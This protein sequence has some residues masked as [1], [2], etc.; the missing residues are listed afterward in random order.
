[1][2]LWLQDRQGDCIDNGEFHY[3]SDKYD[4][5]RVISVFHER[6]PAISSMGITVEVEGNL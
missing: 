2:T 5:L 4:G 1:M 6:Y 3:L